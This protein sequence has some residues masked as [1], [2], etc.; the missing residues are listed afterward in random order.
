MPDFAH[1]SELF[2]VYRR[3]FYGV[4][5]YPNYPKRISDIL[6]IIVRPLILGITVVYSK[7]QG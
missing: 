3:G 6:V 4:R 2:F 1:G 7:L 5:V